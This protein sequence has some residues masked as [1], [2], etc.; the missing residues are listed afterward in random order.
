MYKTLAI[1]LIL[2][3]LSC[4]ESSDKTTENK[5]FHVNIENFNTSIDLKLSDLIDSCWLVQLETTD[6]SVLGRYIDHVYISDKYL[7]I[8]DGTGIFKFSSDGKF[9]KKLI[10]TG[11]GPDEL[12]QTWNMYYSESKDLLLIDDYLKNKTHFLCYDVNS[13]AFMPSVKKFYSDRWGAFAILGDSLIIG[14]LSPFNEVSNPYALFFQDFKGNFISGVRSKRA[15]ITFQN[16]TDAFQKMLF[17][18]GDKFFHVKYFLDDTIFNLIDNNLIPFLISDYHSKLPEPPHI[19]PVV[20]DRRNVYTEFESSG[21]M[22]FRNQAYMGNQEL[23]FGA[24]ALYRNTYFLVDKSNGKNGRI[25]SYYDNF[26]GKT[27][28]DE[29]EEMTFPSFLPNNKLY[30]FYY[31]HELLQKIPDDLVNKRFSESV[32][33]QLAKIK[34]NINET[35]NPILLIGKPKRSISIFK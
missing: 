12:S 15:F 18:N 19:L 17:Y 7:L 1:A 11:R 4:S 29:S 21:F 20:G 13:E 24:K 5:V 35:D 27:Q 16:K 3:L 33:K 22:I 25:R 32:Y 31:P 8:A 26:I 34:S 10:S 2:T 9:I 14:S 28:N 23:G 6:K 30:V